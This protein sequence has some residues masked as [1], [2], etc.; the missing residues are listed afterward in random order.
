MADLSVK[1]R[2]IINAPVEKVFNA[3]LNAETLS[4]FM[5]P[6]PGMSEPR[7]DVDGRVGG[8]F[9]IF[10]M[11]GDQ[12]I[13][14][15]G[16]Y[17]EINAPHKLVFTWESPFSTKDSTVTILFT[18]IDDDHTEIDFTHV[19]FKDEEARANHEGGWNRILEKLSDVTRSAAVSA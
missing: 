13:P 8:G 17:L 6:A 11:V 4:Q 10:M 15:K 12:E 9:T 19:K 5:L 18:P 1:V 14:H 2:R 16:Q 3:W 7:T